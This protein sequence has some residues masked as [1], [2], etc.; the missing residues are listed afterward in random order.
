MEAQRENEPLREGFLKEVACELTFGGSEQ[1]KGS[2]MCKGTEA[3]LSLSLP[4]RGGR[5][6]WWEGDMRPREDGG[7]DWRAEGSQLRSYVLGFIRYR[8]PCKS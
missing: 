6:W 1:V 5:V 8:G 3:R 4:R 7:P 2:S